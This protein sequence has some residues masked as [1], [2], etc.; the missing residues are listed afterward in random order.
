RKRLHADH[1]AGRWAAAREEVG[2]RVADPLEIPG[3]AVHDVDRELGDVRRRRPAYPKHRREAREGLRR[4]GAEVAG[5][6]ERAGTVEGDLTRHV[7][8]RADAHGVGEPWKRSERPGIDEACGDGLRHMLDG[9]R[10]RSDASRRQ[11]DDD[12]EQKNP[13]AYAPVGPVGP[14]VTAKLYTPRPG[15]E[16]AVRTGIPRERRFR[17][18]QD[19]WP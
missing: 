15:R 9:A 17:S 13:H 11:R 14:E 16:F 1:D 12:T 4:L 5:A 8:R 18:A 10:R 19:S 2:R 7:Q 3:S 6:D